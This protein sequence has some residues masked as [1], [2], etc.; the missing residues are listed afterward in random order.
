MEIVLKPL[1]VEMVE[2]LIAKG[3]VIVSDFHSESG[4]QDLYIRRVRMS[5][6]AP[7][8]PE[9]YEYTFQ[10]VLEKDLSDSDPLPSFMNYPHEDAEMLMLEKDGD[11]WR[12]FYG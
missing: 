2:M 6:V 11:K 10:G 5:V 4:T 1:V 12:L 7:K 3:E 8:N 9:E